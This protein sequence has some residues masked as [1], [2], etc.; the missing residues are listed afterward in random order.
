[1][2]KHWRLIVNYADVENPELSH[3]KE[4]C[5]LE[6]TPQECIDNFNDSLRPSE[7]ARILLFALELKGT[8]DKSHSWYKSKPVTINKGGRIY[9]EYTCST[10]KAKGKR[11][12]L[13]DYVTANRKN[14]QLYC[15][16]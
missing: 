1:M 12:N 16:G 10:C 4:D 3:W 6:I 7:K 8:T 11:F 2:K 15:K 5:W 9:D 14:Q 13:N